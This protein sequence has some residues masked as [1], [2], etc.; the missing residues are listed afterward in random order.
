MT[1]TIRL[2]AAV[3][4]IVILLLLT[5]CPDIFT[6][7]MDSPMDPE[8]ESYQGYTTVDDVNEVEPVTVDGV[9]LDFI[10]F[11]INEVVGADAYRLQIAS[12]TDFSIPGNIL[13]DKNDY[14]T[15]VMPATGNVNLTAGTTYYWRAAAQKDGAWGVWT[16]PRTCMMNDLLAGMTPADGTTTTDTTP[17]LSWG[18][19]DGA[20]SYEVQVADTEAGVA[21]ATATESAGTTFTPTTA[22]TN[23]ATHYWRVRAVDADG[24]ATAWSGTNGLTVSWGSITGMSPADG[25]TVSDTTPELSWDAVDGAAKYEVQIADSE[26]GV[27]D[28]TAVEVSEAEYTPTDALTNNTTH[29]WRVRAV[30][31]DG[32]GTAWST[33]T[34]LTISWGAMTGLSPADG[35]TVSDT[36]PE[37]SWDA[38]NGAEKYEVQVAD[39]EAGVASA[40]ATESAGTTFTPTT[41]LTNN[42]THYWRVRAVDADGQAT[43][44]SGTNGLTVSWGSITG[45]SPAD[46][47]TVSD[48]TPELS[49]DAVD[50]AAKYEVQIADSEAGVSDATAVEVSDAEYTPTD[51]LTNNTTHWWRVRAVD[52]AGGKTAW[53]DLFSIILTDTPVI[54]M[55]GPAGGIVFYD[56]G[57]DSDGWRYLEAA[58]SDIDVSGGYTHVWG[59]YGTEVGTSAQGTAIGTGQ[60]NTTAIVDKY[61]DSD[62]SDNTGNYAARLADRYEYG[63]FDDWFLPSKDELNLMYQKRGVIGGFA[64]NIY[65]SSSE[66][67]S[68]LAWYQYFSNGYQFS[69]FKFSYVRVR[70]CR[71]F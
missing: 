47:E 51:A 53:S 21:S 58:P 24:Q 36:T 26:A 64:S 33:T 29:W 54:G 8:A 2:S 12:D 9:N 65:W 38:V 30:D 3:L 60:A 11:T 13:F 17:E 50:G 67:F 31:A 23:N 57:N 52:D 18:A 16:E 4:G 59:G 32:E 41:A 42:A 25:E 7:N 61:G 43:A 39:T 37:L 45:M 49:W 34:S 70:A 44:W 55:V 46:G 1:R 63:G 62:P 22:L 15:R 35:E 71:A 6:A 69:T 56:K 10:S 19:V 40:T 27:S 68:N 66:F 5:G 28:A 14:T 20:A 48:T